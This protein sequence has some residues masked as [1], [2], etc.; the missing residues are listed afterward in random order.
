MG[1]IA[2]GSET[3]PA[4]EAVQT[5]VGVHVYICVCFVCTACQ[6]KISG[7]VA[8]LIYAASHTP[9]VSYLYPCVFGLRAVWQLSVCPPDY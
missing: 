8:A 1:G 7:H 2:K 4:L 6:K 5:R 9:Q 3:L